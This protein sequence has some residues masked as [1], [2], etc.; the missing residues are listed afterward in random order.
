MK[1]IELTAENVKRL[2]AVAIRPDGN[3]VEISGRNGQ[4]KSSVLD[5]IWWALAGQTP[6]QSV[7]IRKGEEE[8]RIRLDLGEIKVIR[9]FKGRED[10]T[11]STSIVV[12]SQEGARFPSPQKMLD[13]LL[14][15]LSFDPL[16]FT[17][18][19]GKRQLE[20]LKR[21]VPGV[22]FAA[23]EKANRVDFEK[24]TDLNREVRTLRAQAAGIV[25]P[26]DTPAERIDDAALVAE[27]E[28]AAEHNG[29]IE[30]R[31]ANR[32]AFVADVDRMREEE[33]RIE[34]DIARLQASREA[35]QTKIAAKVKQL[36]EAE[37]LPAPIDTASL[38]ERIAAAREVNQAVVAREQRDRVE[39]QARAV[40]AQAAALTTAIE[41]RAAEKRTA[42]EKA[43][44][45]VPGITFGEDEILLNGV[46]FDQASSSEQLRT[47]VAIAIAANPKLRVIRVQDGSLLDEE[48][49]RILAEMADAADCQVWVE[50]VQSGRSTAIVIEDGQVRGAMQVAAEAAE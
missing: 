3:L 17:R 28:R 18:M 43:D 29:Q 44:L 37:A 22:D 9:T 5:A 13:S 35:L 46:P 15:Q 2:K 23:I 6:I 12:E 38:R 10:G 14:G 11:F 36:N 19:D 45:P 20:A 8:A 21:F 26:A 32:E 31:K 50:V 24:R 4:G 48:A 42:I 25:V 47:S 41:K 33:R 39:A 16:A 27:M 34:T 40:E 49:M 7:P 1:I 30:R